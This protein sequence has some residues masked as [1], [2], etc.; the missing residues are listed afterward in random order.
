MNGSSPY[1]F[2]TG[3]LAFTNVVVVCGLRIAA[4]M[5]RHY[6]IFQFIVFLS[7]ILWIPAVFIFDA[8]AASYS[9]SFDYMYGGARQIF[10]SASFWLGVLL[11]AGLCGIKM[12][13]WKA[14][15]RFEWPEFRHIVQE[16]SVYTKEFSSI[17]RYH[18]T[19]DFARR[20]GKSITEVLEEE[21]VAATVANSISAPTTSKETRLV[22][23][24]VAPLS[25][26]TMDRSHEILEQVYAMKPLPMQDDGKL[27]YDPSNDFDKETKEE[28][29]II[30]SASKPKLSHTQL[31]SVPSFSTTEDDE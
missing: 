20:T 15:R 13:A 26:T 1:I 24:N 6:I 9:I 22:D 16:A 4:E 12:M 28:V 18:E 23:V 21:I 8:L 2:L 27:K 14:W 29:K 10:T 25:P 3:T 5:N 30:S 11:F 17:K 31:K 7:V 19:A